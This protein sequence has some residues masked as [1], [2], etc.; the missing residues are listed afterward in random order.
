MLCV[1][2]ARA[3]GGA[4]ELPLILP[5][6]LVGG[7]S[8]AAWTLCLVLRRPL[9]L[10]WVL[11]LPWPG[12]IICASRRDRYPRLGRRND[13]TG[14]GNWY[15][16]G[17]RRGR[18]QGSLGHRQVAIIAVAADTQWGPGIYGGPQVVRHCRRALVAVRRIH[19]QRF[20]HHRFDSRRDVRAH[21][22]NR[23]QWIAHFPGHN[24][25]GIRPCIWHIPGQ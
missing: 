19:C 22:F 24:R 6:L 5:I 8:K 20:R 9:P 16:R 4:V 14:A 2:A 23:G 25:K 1:R 17:Y 10:T 7:S 21:I 11:V 3:G 12:S 13:T 18:N 15:S